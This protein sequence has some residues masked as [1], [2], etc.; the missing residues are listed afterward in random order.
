LY[1]L[2]IFTHFT[3][4]L[5]DRNFLSLGGLLCHFCLRC[6]FLVSCEVVI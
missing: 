1:Y 2:L 3:L 6:G 4:K 5:S